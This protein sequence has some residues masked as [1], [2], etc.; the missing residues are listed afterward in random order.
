[1]SKHSS[2]DGGLSGNQKL[3]KAV[4]VE[5]YILICA[6]ETIGNQ[7]W[8]SHKKFSRYFAPIGNWAAMF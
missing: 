5:V 6:W 2:Q 1:M 4:K 8:S 7:H 3:L